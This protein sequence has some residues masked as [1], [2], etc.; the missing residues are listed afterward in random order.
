MPSSYSRAAL[1]R[2]IGGR[3]RDSLQMARRR[4]EWG[5]GEAGGEGVWVRAGQEC[6]GIRGASVDLRARFN[7]W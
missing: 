6:D 4:P 3:G 5:L 2:E 1:E 7:D